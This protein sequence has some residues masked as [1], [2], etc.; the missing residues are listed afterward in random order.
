MNTAVT[1][2][3]LV[4]EKKRNVRRLAEGMLDPVVAV[5]PLLRIGEGLYGHER[6]EEGVLHNLSARRRGRQGL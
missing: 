6:V 2:P 5:K 4:T 3:K 1:D